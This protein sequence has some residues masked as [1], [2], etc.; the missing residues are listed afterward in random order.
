MGLLTGHRT[1]Q[2]VQ[3]SKETSMKRTWMWCLIGLISLGSA[4]WSR[5]Q[6][7]GGVEEAVAGLEEQR[8]QGQKTKKP[9][10]VTPL[11]ADK[12]VSPSPESKSSSQAP[13]GAAL[14][15]LVKE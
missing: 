7:T 4:A 9:D 2:K 14:K 6:Q 5:A 10:L 12:I 8:L 3:K 15:N 13:T 1:S 11:L